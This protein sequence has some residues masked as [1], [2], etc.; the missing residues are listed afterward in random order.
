MLFCIV[1][2]D[3]S[4][5]LLTRRLAAQSLLVPFLNRRRYSRAFRLGTIVWAFL[6]PD[7]EFKEIFLFAKMAFISIL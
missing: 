6:D 4:N 5:I 7:P 3:R 1:G 2:F